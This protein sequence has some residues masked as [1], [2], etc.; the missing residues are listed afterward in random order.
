MTWRYDM[1][2][3][4]K[5]QE[6]LRI[7]TGIQCPECYGVRVLAITTPRYRFECQECDTQWGR[8]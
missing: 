1:T 4:Q 3:E 6:Q 5:E 8:T 2:P 7:V